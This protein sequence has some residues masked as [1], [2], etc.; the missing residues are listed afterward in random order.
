MSLMRRCCA[1]STIFGVR[2]HC[3]QSSVG[4]VSESCAM[5][6][7]IDGDFSTRTTS[8]P[9][10]AMSSAAWIPATPPPTTSARRVSGTSIGASASS[11]FAFSTI[12]LTILMAFRVAFS[13]SP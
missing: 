7:P 1:A 2:M 3:E 6:P 5:C 4:N 10:F 13:L 12:V 9:E 11:S 8:Y